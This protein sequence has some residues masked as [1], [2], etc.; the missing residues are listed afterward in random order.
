VQNTLSRDF[1][2]GRTPP[3]F[4][5]V[6]GS[7]KLKFHRETRAV[8]GYALTVTDVQKLMP[9]TGDKR[10]SFSLSETSHPVSG[11]RSLFFRRFCLD[12]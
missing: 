8:D 1:S 6:E 5:Q 9:L 12:T 10:W 7:F 2:L 4:W 3:Y 11:G